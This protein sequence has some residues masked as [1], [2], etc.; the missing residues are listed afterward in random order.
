M[1][2]HATAQPSVDRPLFFYGT[3]RDTDVLAI[4]LDRTVGADEL[5]PAS[6]PAHLCVR[7]PSGSYP[8]LVRAA[9]SEARG[10]L[11]S[12][13]DDRELD[14]LCFFESYEYALRECVARTAGGRRKAWMWGET[15]LVPD[16][17][18]TWSLAA[19]QALEKPGFLPFARRFMSFYE[20]GTE[21]ELDAAEAAWEAM[22]QQREA[23]LPSGS[24]ASG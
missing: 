8:I 1:S 22:E 2:T 17:S 11:F 15:S 10:V 20:H 4:V 19:W 16:A 3:C 21:A 23:T 7:M 5:E 14:R 24:T 6:L 9:A 13:R 12:P 18:R